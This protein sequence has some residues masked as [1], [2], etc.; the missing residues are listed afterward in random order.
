MNIHDEGGL[1]Y[2]LHTF[3]SKWSERLSGLALQGHYRPGVLSTRHSRGPRFG[4]LTQGAHPH[5]MNDSLSRIEEPVREA[6][7]F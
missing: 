6:L 4:D 1:H 2:G 7:R 5:T 3:I